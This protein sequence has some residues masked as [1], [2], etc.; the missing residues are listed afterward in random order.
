MNCL[1]YVQHLEVEFRNMY[2]LHQDWEASTCIGPQQEGLSVDVR[3]RIS[4]F[5]QTLQCIPSRDLHCP[6][7]RY[8]M[9]S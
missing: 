7:R 4:D 5:W 1:V 2:A 6:A 8:V 9:E 3:E